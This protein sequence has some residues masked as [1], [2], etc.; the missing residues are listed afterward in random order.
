MML[1]TQS[2]GDSFTSE[3]KDY[4]ESPFV[5]Q[6]EVCED[7]LK[8]DESNRSSTTW[9][10]ADDPRRPMNWPFN[11]KWCTTFVLS[12]IAFVQPLAETAL[13]PLEDQISS[14]LSIT[15]PYQWILVNS[16]VLV[17]IGLSSLFLGPLSELYGR[18]PMLLAGSIS[19][20]VW[21]TASGGVSSLTQMLVLRLLSG[22]GASVGDAI[23]P[24]VLADIW[25]VELRGRAFAIFYAAPL[26]G[27]GIGPIIG[28]FVTEALN[29][30]WVFW[31]TSAASLVTVF[32]ILAFLAESYEPKI[33]QSLR[34]KARDDESAEAKY[35]DGRQKSDLTTVMKQNLHRPFRMLT[36][37]V[38]IQLLALYMALLYGIMWLFLFIYPLLWTE[39]YGQEPRIASLNYLSFGLGMV[40]G[41]FIAGF[42]ND[43]IYSYLK[44]RFKS[45]GRPEFRVPAMVIGTICAPAGLLI[46]GWSGEAKVHWIVPNLGS[47]VFATGVYICSACVSVYTIDTYTRYAASAVCTNLVLRSLTGAFFP[48]FA[49]YLFEKL[50]FGY[51]ATVLAAGFLVIGVLAMG[52][53]W[54]FGER[55]RSRSPYCAADAGE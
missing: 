30:R 14:T 11:K 52:A 28:I 32:A 43:A 3:K 1:E 23:A 24:G 48:V 27:T 42:I 26:F 18:K 41:V 13:T 17:G 47:F 29:W 12:A 44:L 36:T 54:F 46:W 33:E 25:P 7:V 50:G 21:N 9:S 19:F 51:G 37:Q 34:R 22:F 35:R 40:A 8:N 10:G 49:P 45:S 4:G 16:L 53:L 55:L 15:Q 31:I 6:L 2:S 39:Q 5:N 20:I 38:I